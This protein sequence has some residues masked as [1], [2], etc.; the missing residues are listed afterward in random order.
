MKKVEKPKK[1]LL[2]Y[3]F[4]TMVVLILLNTFL[5]PL[6]IRKNQITE[7]DYGTF[8]NMVESKEVSRVELNGDSIYFV[9]TDKEEPKYYAT[10]TF[11]D[12]ELVN[13][14]EDAGCEFGRVAEKE[15]NPILNFLLVWIVPVSYTHLTLPTNWSTA[16]QLYDEKDGWRRR[17]KSIYVLR[18]KQCQGLC[19]I[20]N[21]NNLQ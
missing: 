2:F 15:M 8:L 13:R 9:D 17:R 19:G 10:T 1:P 4:V 7:V 3:Y 16:Q 14:L 20:Y 5:F 6:L 18:E 11:D 21:R 12:P